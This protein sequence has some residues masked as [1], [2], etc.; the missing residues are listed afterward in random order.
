MPNKP[1]KKSR[2]SGIMPLEKAPWT[3]TH[4]ILT[5][6][7]QNVESLPEKQDGEWNVT[8]PPAGEF[9]EWAGSVYYI[10]LYWLEELLLDGL[11]LLSC[12]LLRKLV[13]EEFFPVSGNLGRKTGFVQ[14]NTTGNQSR[15]A[16][17]YLCKH[18]RS[19]QPW[20]SASY[21][22]VLLQFDRCSNHNFS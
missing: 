2:K 20:G 1:E 13:T 4:S 21:V 6:S 3:Q 19:Y 8:Y 22:L 10:S 12:I 9:T 14:W 16:K 7:V 18:L 17:L 11:H 15:K 5:K